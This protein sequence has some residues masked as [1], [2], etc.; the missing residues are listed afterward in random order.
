MKQ[1]RQ[2][3]MGAK[4]VRGSDAARRQAAQAKAEKV[5]D[6]SGDWNGPVP[7]FLKFSAL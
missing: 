5:E 6:A 4:A 2:Q 7:S 3:P 1:K